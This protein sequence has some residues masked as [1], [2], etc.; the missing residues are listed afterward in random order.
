M[1]LRRQL[2]GRQDGSRDRLAHYKC[3][4]RVVYGPLPKTDTGKIQKY[5][6]RELA[7]SREAITELE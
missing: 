2:F 5:R 7:K 6:L 4:V 3:P 1:S